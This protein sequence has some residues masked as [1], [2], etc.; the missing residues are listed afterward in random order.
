MQRSTDA[1]ASRQSRR[2]Q[3]LAVV[4]SVALACAAPHPA[5]LPQQS[6]A[7]PAAGSGGINAP[8]QR[9]KPYLILISL[10]GFKPAYLDAF[11][12]PHLRRLARRGA[13]ASALIAVFPSLTFPNHY[14]LVTGLYPEHHGIVANTF[15][16]PAFRAT[17][18]LSN[19]EAVGDAR[20]Y[21][22]VPIWV[23]AE[24]QGMVAACFFWPGSEAPIGGVRPTMWRTYDEGIGQAERVR[25]VIDWLRLPVERRPHV[26]TL[27]FSELDSA[28]HNHP[29]DSPAIEEAAQSIDRSIGELVDAIAALPIRDRVY[30]LLTSDHGMA[31]LT[32]AREIALAPLVDMSDVEHAFG[33]PVANLH[34]RGGAPAAVRVRDSLNARLANGRAYLRED[35][36][37]R[38]HYRADPRA[39]DVVVVMDEGWTLITGVRRLVRPFRGRRGMHGWDPALLSMHA[40][41]VAVGPGIRAGVVLGEVHNVDV[42]PFMTELLGL[43]PVTSIDGRAGRI[44]EQVIEAA[45]RWPTMRNR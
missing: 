14:S 3:V 16:D 27:Y 26:I 30:L 19:T 23:S 28:S 17:Y 21:R 20:W 18:S 41:F 32:P 8:E 4:A 6:L 37:E 44:F 29:L 12:L 13:R 10:D 36:P 33:G 39:G 45:E 1:G 38:F 42:Y 34:V 31:E 22:G 43:R 2:L 7:A 24:T 25:T 40:L 35:L 9:D 11:D 15:Y 5:G